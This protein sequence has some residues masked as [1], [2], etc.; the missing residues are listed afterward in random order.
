MVAGW[1]VGQAFQQGRKQMLGCYDTRSTKVH[2]SI[3]N[4]LGQERPCVVLKVNLKVFSAGAVNVVSWCLSCFTL[5]K[6]SKVG[7]A[8]PAGG[9]FGEVLNSTANATSA[10]TTK[11]PPEQTAPE[12]PT[13]VLLPTA[14]AAG[15]S[16][17]HLD[18]AH[19]CGFP[20]D[21]LLFSFTYFFDQIVDEWN[22][23]KSLDL[24]S[25]ETLLACMEGPLY[26]K[27]HHRASGR[28]LQATTVFLLKITV[29]LDSSFIFLYYLHESLFLGLCTLNQF[30]T[31]CPFLNSGY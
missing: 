20:P 3:C 24:H 17:A 12:L 10:M 19:G 9:D 23:V 15:D 21:V 6:K 13:C 2:T 1:S 22:K 4:E 14:G 16:Q 28:S 5:F 25:R 30:L 29:H 31:N 18:N 27:Q 8:K 26:R 7:G 11:P